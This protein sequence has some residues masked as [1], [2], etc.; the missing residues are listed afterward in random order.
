MGKK[1]NNKELLKIITKPQKKRER[2]CLAV[3]TLTLS[4]FGLFIAW[5]FWNAIIQGTER[6]AY[7]IIGY[8][9]PIGLAIASFGGLVASLQVAKRQ[10]VAVSTIWTVVIVGS[11]SFIGVAIN[12]VVA[13]VRYNDVDWIQ[14]I[15]QAFSDFSVIEIGG[16]GL[17]V[18]TVVTLAI[19]VSIVVT[20]ILKDKK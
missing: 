12:S 7:D 3:V 9:V 6:P 15:G 2:V 10:P 13:F 20:D 18:P 8:A 14:S 11:I 1:S 17:S 5:W 16:V 19:V 4:L